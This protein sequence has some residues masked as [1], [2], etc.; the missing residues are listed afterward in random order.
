MKYWVYIL[1]S[2]HLDKYYVGSTQDI[3]GRLRRHLANHKGF[4]SNAKDWVLK[5]QE[6]FGTKT[7]AVKRELQIKK[8]KS[9]VMIE[10][11]I[12]RR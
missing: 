8:W 3:E 6:S 9:R 10:R 7:E 5:Y 12:S 2:G 4:T 11:L 1:Y